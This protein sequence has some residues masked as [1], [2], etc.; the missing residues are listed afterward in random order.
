MYLKKIAIENMGPIKTIVVDLP[1]NNE[2]NP[3]P[4][5]LVGEN[6]TGKTIF[7]SLIVDALHELENK[8]FTDIL[9]KEGYGYKYY[10]ITSFYR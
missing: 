4:L 3:K 1:F 9:P 2:G 8:V 7:L 10:K 5:M 6:G